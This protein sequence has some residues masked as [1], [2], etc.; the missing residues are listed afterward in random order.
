M[1]HIIKIL[2]FIFLF[3]SNIYGSLLEWYKKGTITINSSIGF[4]SDIDDEVPLY[5]AGP[6]IAISSD[7]TIY[8]TNCEM[9]CIL[10]F[11]SMG[12]YKRK[13]GVRGVGP[14]DLYYPA[15]I[16][17]LDDK[18]LVVQEYALSRRISI[19]SLSGSF[20]KII[21]TPRASFNALSLKNNRIAYLSFKH[22]SEN[23]KQWEK[24]SLYIIDIQ[25]NQELLINSVEL[26]DTNTIN[27][28][29]SVKFGFG[30]NNGGCMMISRTIDGDLLAGISN[31]KIMTIYSLSGQVKKTFELKLNCLKVTDDYIEKFKASAL[32]AIMVDGKGKLSKSFVNKIKEYPFEKMFLEYLP[33][34]KGF[35][36]D[37]QGNIL[38][39]PEDDFSDDNKICF[40]VYSPEGQFVC[41][42]KIDDGS[43]NIN[44]S[45]PAKNLY[46]TK[47]GIIGLL[48]IRDSEDDEKRLVKVDIENTK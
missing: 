39:F 35:Q 27:I 33:Y 36:V 22:R 25:T 7:G 3:S 17:I 42:T 45:Q 12:K 1:N 38:V 41:E 40:Q 11:D 19:F 34:Y 10:V 21:K 44:D 26:P 15:Q 9:H 5:N 2:I 13:I 6:Y 16:S 24:T 31:S 23:K 28:S 32:R 47:N 43:F 29:S 37:G 14:G 8:V 18:Y 48:R 46:F 20:I 30:T 4:A